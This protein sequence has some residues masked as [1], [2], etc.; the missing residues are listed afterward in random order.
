MIQKKNRFIP[1]DLADNLYQLSSQAFEFGAPWTKAQFLEDLGHEESQY[2]LSWGQELQGFINYRTMIDEAELVNLAIA[3]NYQGQQIASQLLVELVKELEK[4]A[5]KQLFL[6][7]RLSNVA[8]QKLY[9]K[10][11]FKEIGR[12]KKYYRDPQEEAILMRLELK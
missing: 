8:A 1:S 5:I 2:L 4:K 10:N 12:R 6:E 3:P 7:V 11:G 9:L